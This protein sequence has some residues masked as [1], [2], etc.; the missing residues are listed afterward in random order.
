MIRL[1]CAAILAAYCLLLSDRNERTHSIKCVTVLR[2][3][4]SF[5]VCGTEVFQSDVFN[6]N[7]PIN[8]I[9][10]RLDLVCK[11]GYNMFCIITTVRH[12]LKIGTTLECFLAHVAT[13]M[14]S[15]NS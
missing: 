6:K 3:Q 14:H 2:I 7:R 5:L 15:K 11:T 9:V 13:V 12:I 1:L 4:E 8:K 10:S